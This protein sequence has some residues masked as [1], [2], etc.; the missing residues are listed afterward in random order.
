[1]KVGKG[2]GNGAFV[3]ELMIKKAFLESLPRHCFRHPV[4]MWLTLSQVDGEVYKV[5]DFK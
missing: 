2:V 5:V 4:R 1:M 3:I